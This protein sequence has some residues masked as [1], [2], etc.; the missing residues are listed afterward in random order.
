[1]E[2]AGDSVRGVP[3]ES[4]MSSSGLRQSD[5]DDDDD[6]I[7]SQYPFF[8]LLTNDSPAGSSILQAGIDQ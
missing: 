4:P 8:L 5:G 7:C 2:M 3:L 1:M 6:G